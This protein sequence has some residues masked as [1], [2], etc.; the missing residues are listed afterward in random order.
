M[1]SNITLCHMIVVSPLV[2]QG[3]KPIKIFLITIERFIAYNNKFVIFQKNYSSLPKVTSF[4][5][6]SNPSGY[7]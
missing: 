5:L 4:E 7:S 2:I 3:G 6:D 1:N